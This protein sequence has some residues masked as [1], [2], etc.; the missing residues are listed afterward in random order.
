[1]SSIPRLALAAALTG[2]L[3][4]AAPGADAAGVHLQFA[5]VPATIAPHDTFTVNVTV[6]PGDD[7]FNAFDLNIGYDPTHLTFV[8]TS[9]VSNQ[10]G[11]LMTAAC[12]NTFHL[13]TPTSGVLQA[14]LSLLCNGVFVTGPGIIYKVRFAATDSVGPTTIQCE[15]GSQFY[16]AGFFVNPLDCQPLTVSV[17]GI[18][19]APDL[20]DPTVMLSLSTPTPGS[21]SASGTT[22]HIEF[23]L[24]RA[25]TARLELFDVRG[26]LLADLPPAAYQKGHNEVSWSLPALA[27]GTYFVRLMTGSGLTARRNWVL[28]R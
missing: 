3:L 1:M 14:T 26:R 16:R 12:A 7:P 28:V 15:A 20:G 8:P 22:T 24:P 2:L 21:R 25:D 18:S 27:S 9:P 13:F 23:Q 6:N 5:A 4:S 19:S 17:S 10:R 11:A